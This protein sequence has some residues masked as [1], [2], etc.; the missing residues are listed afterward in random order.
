MIVCPHCGSSEGYSRAVQIRGSGR[1]TYNA[2]GTPADNSHLHD[3]LNYIEGVRM[4]CIS[5]LK[6]I[7]KVKEENDN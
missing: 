5:C 4:T 7:G 2:D 3:L 1:F 6:Y